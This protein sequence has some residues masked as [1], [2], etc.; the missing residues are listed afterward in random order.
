[1]SMDTRKLVVLACAL[2]VPGIASAITVS[3]DF[4]PFPNANFGGTGIPNDSVAAST[5]IIDGTTTI[6]IAMSATQRFSNPA[7]SNNGSGVYFAGTGSNFGGAGESATEGALWNWNYYI[8]VDGGQLTDYQIDIY[9]DFDP[10]AGNALGTLGRL[11]VTATLNCGI[12]CGADPTSTLEQGSQ[13]LMFGF[14]AVPFPP[15][16]NPPAGA[17][18][19][20]ITGNYQFAIVVSDPSFGFP[21]ETLAIEVSVVPVP[22]AV[23]LFGSALGLLGWMRRKSA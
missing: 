13:N 15:L 9:Y 8:E 1:M 16:V 23:W 2:V 3:D 22:A 11:D 12:V 6:T 14:L 17:F 19:P 10:I 21:V 5:Q 18:N 7:L 20:N 4:G